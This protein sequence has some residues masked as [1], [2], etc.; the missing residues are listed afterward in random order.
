MC[1]LEYL[2]INLL[3]L[4][5][6]LSFYLFCHYYHP[7]LFASFYYI[8]VRWI[9]YKVKQNHHVWDPMDR[10]PKMNRMESCKIDK[11]NIYEHLTRFKLPF[12]LSLDIVIFLRFLLANHNYVCQ[13]KKNPSLSIDE[14]IYN[15]RTSYRLIKEVV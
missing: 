6:P 12:I 1:L 2:L 15:W 5:H 14:V 7:H 4:L 8:S 13:L 3:L 10:H 11:K 9:K